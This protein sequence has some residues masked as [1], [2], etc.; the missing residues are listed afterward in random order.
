MSSEQND[1][2]FLK[3]DN[4]EPIAKQTR[5][6]DILIVDDDPE[7]HSVTKLALSG[8]S[9]GGAGLCFHDAYSGAEARGILSQANTISVIFLD[10]VMETDDA[11]LQ[12]V[13]YIREEMKNQRVRIIMRTGQSGNMPE[14]KVIREYDINDYKTKTELTRSKLVVSL[15]TAIRSYE[16]ICQFEYQSNAMNTVLSASKSILGLTDIHAL[17]KGIVKYLAVIM[18]CRPRGL[19]CTKLDGDN[20][21]QVLG[22]CNHYKNYFGE[23]LSE[24]DSLIFSR[25][26]DSFSQGRH[27]N[28]TGSATFLLKSKNRKAAVY[29]EC[30]HP[31]TEIQLQFAELFLT[32]IS[33]ALD[34]IRLFVKLRDAAYKDVLTGVSNRNNF[35]EQIEQFQKP[36]KN[37]YVFV[38]LDISHFSDINNG[39]GQDVGNNTP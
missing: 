5:F 35:I 18:A 23:K 13:K 30:D 15:I 2:L 31:L 11:G 36:H 9:F 26:K 38:L 4:D 24:V 27:I 14:E 17:C 28:A 21:I 20:F 6:W 22:G 1:F 29:I 25:V 19:I 32:N 16:Q 34:N 33:I 10:V 12:L 39:L 7:I 37:D 3:Q 8:I